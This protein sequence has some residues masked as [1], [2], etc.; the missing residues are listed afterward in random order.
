MYAYDFYQYTGK[1]VLL[2]DLCFIVKKTLNFLYSFFDL[3]WS[4]LECH[5]QF[6]AFHSAKSIPMLLIRSLQRESKREMFVKRKKKDLFCFSLP[7]VFP[8]KRGRVASSS[9]TQSVGPGFESRSGHL[10]DLFLVF[11]SSNP[12]PCL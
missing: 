9:D 4:V 7:F 6:S 1:S 5:L 11:L 3:W 8:C 12:Q 2:I 10:L